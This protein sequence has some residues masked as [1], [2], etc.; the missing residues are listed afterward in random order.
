MPTGVRM[1]LCV[2]EMVLMCICELVCKSGLCTPLGAC[3]KC[4]RVCVSVLLCVYACVLGGW[5]P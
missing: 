4:V 1:Q 3:C 5:T 2:S